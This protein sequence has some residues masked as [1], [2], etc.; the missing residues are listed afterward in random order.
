V[1]VSDES[2]PLG[3][4]RLRNTAASAVIDAI[5][6][7]QS[8]IRNFAQFLWV[9]NA[10]IGASRTL[11]TLGNFRI[12]GANPHRSLEIFRIVGA[13]TRVYFQRAGRYQEVR[14][15][16]RHPE[17]GKKTYRCVA[18]WPVG[19]T[20]AE[21]IRA[22]NAAWERL[23]RLLAAKMGLKRPVCWVAAAAR[24]VRSGRLSRRDLRRLARFQLQYAALNR[25]ALGL[26][27]PPWSEQ[28]E[29][30]FRFEQSFRKRERE[31]RAVLQAIPSR[32]RDTR[33]T[34][35]PEAAI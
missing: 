34:A 29:Q 14:E 24:Y 9:Q 23:A 18:R 8:Y 2:A 28:E 25:A 3:P 10:A 32:A 7:M 4:A 13:K 6:K 30:F 17:T 31:A 15:A 20:L 33:A 1:T 12:V 22:N 35:E 16:Y 21:E 11:Q 19:H 26:R 5:E 27:Q